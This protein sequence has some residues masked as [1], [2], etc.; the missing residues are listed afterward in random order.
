MDYIF[1][2]N[3]EGAV[4]SEQLGE[5]KQRCANWDRGAGTFFESR[6]YWD[7]KRRCV[8]GGQSGDGRHWDDEK[9]AGDP[10]GI[11]NGA[12]DS[13]MRLADD[14]ISTKR[15]TLL[16]AL[17]LA[18]VNF[19]GSGDKATEM[20][21]NL[22]T[23]WRWLRDGMESRWVGAWVQLI[24]WYLADSP[25]VAMMRVSWMKDTWLGK[26]T[27]TLQEIGQAW[28]ARELSRGGD[29][30]NEFDVTAMVEGK[31]AIASAYMGGM[32]E[33]ADEA[34]QAMAEAQAVLMALTG[35]DAGE[36]TRKMKKIVAEGQASVVSEMT[37]AEG[38]KLEALR[39]GQDFIIA[40]DCR[41][42][43]D[44]GMWFAAKW[45]TV[46]EIEAQEDWDPEFKERVIAQAGYNVLNNG[47]H[48]TSALETQYRQVVYAYVVGIDRKGRKG[49][50]HC[51]F[52]SND[53]LTAYGWRLVS[54]N[55]GKWPAVLF[56]REWDGSLA[57]DSRGVTELTCA[58]EG[59]AK[60]MWD[61]A[62]NNAMLG[63]MPPVI[64]KGH[65]VRN[66]LINPLKHIN[67]GVNDGVSYMQPP[68]YP[69]STKLVADKFEMKA[70]DFHG[71]RH[72][73][74]DPSKVANRE[75]AEVNI[76]L[77]SVSDVIRRMIEICQE[78]GSDAF[79]SRVTDDAGAPARLRMADIDG[80]FLVRVTMDP[81][82]MDP[83]RLAEKGQVAAQLLQGLDKKGIIDTS[84]VVAEIMTSMFPALGSKIVKRE[85]VAMQDELQEEAKNLGMIRNG[86]MPTMDTRG[87][88]NYEAR[89]GMYQQMQQENPAVFA[90]MAQDKAEMLQRWVQALQQQVTQFGENRQIGRT[91]VEGVQ[92]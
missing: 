18:N 88:W 91:G 78:E 50:Y 92:G 4:T 75:Q 59:L 77:S 44:Y 10:Q 37:A 70:K 86:V 65:S 5:L 7:Q 45:M 40:D 87:L 33:M 17:M 11:F 36:A 89:L 76:F 8:W 49:K 46:E 83:E 66:Q 64:L 80:Q 61:G 1:R 51:V 47:V 23:L 67:V 57:L 22:A 69:A 29:E 26:R 42:F 2:I 84:P 82:N 34:K 90:D 68:A 25:A 41:D 13:R 72:K 19:A 56:R 48:A 43:A 24:N 81:S 71:I 30:I 85:A 14:I 27:V 6:G 32:E 52:G 20:K 38:V 39:Y 60:C 3:G 12:A 62:A 35:C 63:N 21:E 53:E 79:I 54:G 55:A 74:A 31:L 16:G 73:E 28:I 9:A 15:D 58:D